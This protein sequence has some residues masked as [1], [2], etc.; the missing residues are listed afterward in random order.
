MKTS[1]RKWVARHPVF[2]SLAEDDLNVLLA[3]AVVHDLPAETVLFTQ[4]EHPDFLHLLID[5]R[6]GLIGVGTAG[7]QVIVEFMEPGETFILAAV[8]T[9]AP[10][11]MS[12]TTIQRSRVML[13][14]A[15]ALREHVS[16]NAK[17]A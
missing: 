15:K 6:V 11:L 16:S 5:G 2:E 13:I 14:P 8:L 12:A 1:D 4:G 9:D 7:K 10:Y 17:L 3:S